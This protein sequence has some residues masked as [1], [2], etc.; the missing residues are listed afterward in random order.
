[1]KKEIIIHFSFLILLFFLISL[2]RGWLNLSYWVFWFGGI[3]GTLLPDLEHLVY[4]YFSRPYE[5]T[6]QRVKQMLQGRRIVQALELLKDTRYER[7]HLIFHTIWFQVVF[8][9]LAFWILTSSGSILG[10]GLVLAFLL[11]LLIDQ[12][13]DLW[14]LGNLDKWLSQMPLALDKNQSRAYWFF[15]FLLFLLLCFVF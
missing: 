8:F 6:S 1:M 14:K 13:L 10:R 5:L 15:I 4:V 9:F 7:T 3:L 2:F 11:H 12:V